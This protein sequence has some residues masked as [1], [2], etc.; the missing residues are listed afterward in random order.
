MSIGKIFALKV[1]AS[2]L[3]V[4]CSVAAPTPQDLPNDCGIVAAEAYSRLKATGCWTRIIA[5]HG[6]Y[7][8]G[9][10]KPKELHHVLT[11]YQYDPSAD[12]MLFDHSGSIHLNTKSRELKDI[13]CSLEDLAEGA[14]IIIESEFIS[15]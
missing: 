3:L 12:V 7:I 15:E 2:I 8:D 14:V 11:A 1:V 13:I 10:G 5:L 9:K 6:L 4:G